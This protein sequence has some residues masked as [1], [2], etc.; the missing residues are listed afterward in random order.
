VDVKGFVG[1]LE[2]AVKLVSVAG[3]GLYVLALLVFNIFLAKYGITD[4]A[5][6][7]PQCLFTGAWAFLLLA[8]AATPVVLF[9]ANR[10]STKRSRWQRLTTATAVLVAA[11]YF[12]SEDV[13]FLFGQLLGIP[14]YDQGNLLWLN[15]GIPGWTLLL[16]MTTPFGLFMDSLARIG[17]RAS[18]NTKWYGITRVFHRASSGSSLSGI[19]SA[20]A[21]SGRWA[22]G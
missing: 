22:G 11:L 15:P 12:V 17:L 5:A 6:L 19:P 8:L 13:Y 18:E 3:I 16:L 14:R 7:K 20:R 10:A 9:D 1:T 4:F 21:S 2:P